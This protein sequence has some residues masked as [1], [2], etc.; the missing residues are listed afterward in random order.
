MLGKIMSVAN[1]FKK[2]RNYIYARKEKFHRMFQI[3]LFNYMIFF[4]QI[5]WIGKKI[6]R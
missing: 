4:L 2:S 3:D 6:S 1:H 5:K